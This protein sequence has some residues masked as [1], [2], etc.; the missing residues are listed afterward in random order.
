MKTPSLQKAFTLVEMIVVIAILAIIVAIAVP[1]LSTSKID[2]EHA[3]QDANTTTL[4]QGLQRAALKGDTSPVLYGTDV[5][6]IATYLLVNNY[7]Q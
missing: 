2:A 1:A 7:I 6:A 5:E 3:A 4:N